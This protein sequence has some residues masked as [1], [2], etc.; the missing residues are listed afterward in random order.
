[1]ASTTV[2]VIVIALIQRVIWYDTLLLLESAASFFLS[3][4]VRKL[5]LG[6][7]F[8]VNYVTG[9]VSCW[10]ESCAAGIASMHALHFF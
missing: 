9:I 10:L 4:G 8:K 5:F 1:M 7:L 3:G 2:G 6:I